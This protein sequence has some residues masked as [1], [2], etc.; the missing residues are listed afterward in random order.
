MFKSGI[1]GCILESLLSK[2]FSMEGNNMRINIIRH[3]DTIHMKYVI[4]SSVH[5]L[6][7]YSSR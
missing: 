7:K 5:T 4:E 1:H 2:I 6:E 3:P